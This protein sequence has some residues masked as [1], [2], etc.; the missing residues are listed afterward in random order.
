MPKRGRPEKLDAE[1]RAVLSA[2]LESRRWVMSPVWSTEDEPGI[3]N[4]FAA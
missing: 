1:H 2:I 4:A 3:H